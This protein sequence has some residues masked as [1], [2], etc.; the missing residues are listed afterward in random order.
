[1]VKKFYK[2]EFAPVCPNLNAPPGVILECPVYESEVPPVMVEGCKS[3][4]DVI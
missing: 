3:A 2:H 1:M 4:F